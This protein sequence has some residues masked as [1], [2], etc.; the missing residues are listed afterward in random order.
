MEHDLNLEEVRKVK[1]NYYDCDT[2]DMV[3][4][5]CLV[6]FGTSAVKYDE[7]SITIKSFINLSLSLSWNETKIYFHSWNGELTDD[8]RKQNNVFRLFSLNEMYKYLQLKY[9]ENNF[10]KDNEG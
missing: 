4:K 6:Y 7:N 3:L 1:G 5:I 10:I 9:I 2:Y 8:L